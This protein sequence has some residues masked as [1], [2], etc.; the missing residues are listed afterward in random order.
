MKY[1]TT[2][3]ITASQMDGNYRLTV[4]GILSFHENTVARYLTSLGLAAFDMQKQDKTWIISEINLEMPGLPTI[5]TEDITVTVWISEMS[6]LRIWFEFTA[7]E[8]HSGRLAARGNSCWSLISMSERKPVSCEGIIPQNEPVDE[9]AI[10]PHR[11]R[12]TQASS[13][14]ELHSLGHTIN[15]IDLDFNGHTN[16]RRYIQMALVCFDQEF[17]ETHRPDCLSIRFMH[18]SRMGDSI[19][20]HTYPTDEP[21]TYIGITTNGLGQ[22]LC[23]VTSYWREKEPLPDIAEFNYIRNDTGK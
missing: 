10:G 11:R 8:V 21:D 19:M 17:I 3:P 13:E 9:L 23:R 14:F 12:K 20:N 15:L 5:W 2:Y 4:D 18:E 22:E 6:S 7:V 16:N 1:S